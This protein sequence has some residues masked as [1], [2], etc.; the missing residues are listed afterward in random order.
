MPLLG[1]TTATATATME[2]LSNCHN[3]SA[4]TQ[5]QTNNIDKNEPII[6]SSPSPINHQSE[7]SQ[8]LFCDRSSSG[9]EQNMVHMSKA[10]GLHIVTTN[11]LVHVGSL[12]AYFHLVISCYH[13]CLYCGKQRNTTQ[14]A[15][16]HMIAKGHCKYHLTSKDAEFRE[17]YD[18]SSL[19]TEEEL[20]RALI[21]TLL[22]DSAQLAAHG[23]S[24]KSRSSKRSDIHDTDVTALPRD[25]TPLSSKSPDPESQ[26]DADTTPDDSQTDSELPGQ[27]S[28]R[29]QKQTYIHSNQMAQ[30]RADDRRSLL[31]LL[32]SQQ[33]ALLAT[34]HKQLGKAKRSE[35]VQ[36]GN[37]ESAGNS[38]ARLCTIR[39]IRKPP[40]TGRVQTL[41]R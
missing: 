20:H 3:V 36:R 10:H 16:Q 6:D 26:S 37:L 28:R 39:L 30:L 11:L 34:H 33:R 21:A 25:P 31:H 9:L 4:P 5:E 18:L 13:E 12:L 24:R 15:Q 38:F 2:P 14:A 1:D 40:H 23:R 27:L 19:E 29:A 35:Q 22:S 41:K 17:F 32:A 8:C 7:E